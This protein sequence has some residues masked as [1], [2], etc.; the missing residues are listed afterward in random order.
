MSELLFQRETACI[1]GINVSKVFWV[2]NGHGLD[3]QTSI[4]PATPEKKKHATAI[5][6]LS[7]KLTSVSHRPCI[8]LLAGDLLMRI[9]G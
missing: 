1:F 2:R 4:W 7:P 6:L 9:A 5:D 8:Q 3:R